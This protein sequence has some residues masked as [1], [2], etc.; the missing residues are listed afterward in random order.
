MKGGNS[1]EFGSVFGR[2]N[3]VFCLAFSELEIVNTRVH[4]LSGE[5]E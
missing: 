4:N 5:R 2:N 1:H 3:S